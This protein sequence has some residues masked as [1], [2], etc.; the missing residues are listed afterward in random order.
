MTSQPPV[1]TTTTGLQSLIDLA[2]SMEEGQ[3]LQIP[4][5][6]IPLV[7]KAEHDQIVSDHGGDTF[8]GYGGSKSV[9]NAW[10]S[11]AYDDVGNVWYTM[12]GGHADYGGNEVYAFDMET[13]TWSRLTDPSPLTRVQDGHSAPESGPPSPHTYDGLIW[14]PTTQSLWMIVSAFAYEDVGYFHASPPQ[15]WEFD[16]SSGDWTAH[17]APET[18]RYGTSAYIPETQQILATDNSGNAVLINPDG[19][20]TEDRIWHQRPPANAEYDPVDQVVYQIENSSIWRLEV[21]DTGNIDASKA[22]DIDREFSSIM[23]L[24]EAGMAYSTAAEKWVIT[25]GSP[26]VLI[27]DPKDNSFE[28]VWNAES[29]QQPEYVNRLYDRLEYIE[30]ADVFVMMGTDLEAD[31]GIWLYKIGQDST[32]IDQLQVGDAIVDPSTLNSVGVFIPYLG[33]DMNNDAVVHLSFRE[34]GET[35]WSQGMDLMRIHADRISET[36]PKHYALP[37]VEEG[38]GGSVFGLD[39][40]T[41][42]EIRL[43]ITDPDGV[44]AGDEVQY[45]TATTRSAPSVDG[46]HDLIMVGN[47]VELSTALQQ[48]DAGD[49]IV[50][51]PGEYNGQVLIENSGTADRPIIVTALDRDSTIIAADGASSGV[52]I[53][54]D[55]VWV[56]NLKITDAKLGVRANDTTGATISG[57]VITD[58]TKGIEAK[59]SNFE[60]TIYDNVLEGRVPFGDTSNSTWDYEG[61]VVVGQGIDVFNNTLSG[62]GDALGMNRLKPTHN[63]GIE[64]HHNEVLW[65][66]D[67]GVEFDYGYRN[68][69]AHDNLIANA[70]NGISFQPLWGG[71]A[72]AFNNVI[73][74]TLR[75]PIKVKND[76]TG[77][78]VANNTFIKS[79]TL[80]TNQTSR[81]DN[82]K[83]LNNLFVGESDG[84]TA[85][86]TTTFHREEL[87]YNGWSVDGKFEIKMSGIGQDYYKTFTGYQAGTGLSPHSIILDGEVFQSYDFGSDPFLVQRDVEDIDVSLAP[88]SNAVDAGLI[89][90]T[91]NDDFTGAAPDLGAVELGTEQPEVGATGISSVGAV[92][93]IAQA[94]RGQAVVLDV[95]AND[96]DG[97]GDLIVLA[98]GGSEHGTVK[99]NADGTI[100]YVAD[101]DAPASD[102]FYY[103]VS[104]GEFAIDVASVT[105]FFDGINNRP[106]AQDKTAA[107]DEDGILTGSVIATDEDGDPLTFALAS[108]AANGSASVN[109]D[110]TF[111]YTPNADFSGTDSF[112]YEV[113]D[114]GFSDTATVIVTVT[115]INDAPLAVDAAI[116]TNGNGVQN[117]FVTATDPDNDPL[118]FELASDAANGTVTVNADGS[119]SYT[120]DAN[121]YG[122]DSFSYQVSDGTLTDA[123]TVSINVKPFNNAPVAEDDAVSIDEDTELQGSVSANDVDNDPL[124]YAL[125]WA[126]GNGTVVLNADGTYTYTPD[127]DFH[128]TDSFSYTVSDGDLTD[129]ATISI[130]VDPIND[131]PIALADVGIS[132]ILGLASDVT[133]QVLA[134]DFDA[135]G[136]PLTIEMVGDAVGGKVEL[137]NGRIMFTDD[138]TGPASFRYALSDG[139]GGISDMVDVDLTLD[140]LVSPSLM[141]VSFVNTANDQEII[142]LRP[143]MVISSEDL[144]AALTSIIALTNSDHPD[145]KAVGSVMIEVDNGLTKV[146]SVSPY[147]LF[148][149]RNGSDYLGGTTF[150]EGEHTITL[151]AFDRSH[152]KGN[153][154]ETMT[155]TF[156]VADANQQPTALSDAVTT[157]EEAPISISVL[158]NDSDPDGDPL[159]VSMAQAPANGIATVNADGTISYTPNADFHGTDTF[160]YQVSDGVLADTATVTITVNAVN[161]APV[162]VADTGLEAR[163]GISTDVTDQILANDF[164]ADEDT[165]SIAMVDG[166]VGGTVEIVGGRVLF[167]GDSEGPASFRYALSDGQGGE[168]VWV[169]VDLTVAPPPPPALLT[170]G[171]YDTETDQEIF[172]LKPDMVLFASDLPDDFTTIVANT[173]SDNPDA[174]AV[175]SVMLEVD[176]CPTKVESVKPFALFGDRGASDYLGGTTFDEGTYTLTVT[177]FD[178]GHG[179]GEVLDTMSLT[180]TVVADDPTVDFDLANSSGDTVLL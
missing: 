85:S 140:A 87:D 65:T 136:D 94:A 162:A 108:N 141:K 64:I 114:G 150:D 75:G 90:P 11:A 62:F 89:L 79:G 6:A 157:D 25:D 54:G 2:D 96:G 112:V 71:P 106:V 5:S 15:F 109:A 145:A 127:T 1:D 49:I 51:K 164:D 74:N 23:N 40:N 165:L 131:A 122:A 143:D 78:V 13:L 8:W 169:D 55:H 67:D 22:V 52:E 128:G 148:G 146:E 60:T 123:A 9:I 34:V 70:A 58:V 102:T 72:Y 166:A 77:F 12:G 174:R 10:N 101:G 107:I 134:N 91:I 170:V 18:M 138:G 56:S 142:T 38:F 36:K 32:A 121:F 144:P 161:D 7:T 153:V 28:H 139:Q 92:D 86:L 129:T 84:R 158:A 57:N 4:N 160:A 46:P 59:K 37:P 110:G 61:I 53:D 119:Y 154:L 99:V 152:G 48:A 120:P 83:I 80:W 133:D 104:D 116:S 177:A 132:A 30:E 135:D 173:N 47:N 178:R 126:A 20:Y 69:S 175:R 45:L 17:D 88:T 172:T 26:D 29:N 66:G 113:S 155:L 21:D 81:A 82:F 180:F 163:F 147:A 151:T 73:V 39:P 93:D 50:L 115:P 117:G 125:G 111:T 124:T 167:T 103:V 27:W 42:Y 168:S 137:V 33:G 176:G 41:T 97:S 179:K 118:I 100:T 156:T 149:D 19:S 63:I 31:E 43:E 159:A 105:V 14:N 24:N 44:V 68:I 171:F 16:P 35:D 130:T 95:T 98:V 3:W 76:P